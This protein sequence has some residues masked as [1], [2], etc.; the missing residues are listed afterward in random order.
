MPPKGWL[1]GS[2][3][4][5]FS[6]A[7][8]TSKSKSFSILFRFA[9]SVKNRTFSVFICLRQK[10][11]KSL[12]ERGTDFFLAPFSRHFANKVLLTDTKVWTR[13]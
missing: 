2:G 10:E 9:E 13:I 4:L 6:F 5:S 3:I 1:P 12:L 11:K 8:L 7:S